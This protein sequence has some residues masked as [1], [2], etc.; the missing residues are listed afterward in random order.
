MFRIQSF[1]IMYTVNRITMQYYVSNKCL[2]KTR[3]KLYNCTRSNTR[4]THNVS[5]IPDYKTV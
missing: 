1:T 4:K 5:E 3:F 2:A